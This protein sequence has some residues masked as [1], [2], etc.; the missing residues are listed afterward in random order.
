MAVRPDVQR[1]GHGTRLV[2]AVFAAARD[3][4]AEVVWADARLTAVPFYERLGAT[5]EG[6]VY[7]DVVTGLADQRVVFDLTTRRQ[8]PLSR[9]P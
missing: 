5:A 6:E 2:Q 1:L 4:P 8:V 3:A 9:H 7:V